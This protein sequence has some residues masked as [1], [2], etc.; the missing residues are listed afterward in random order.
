MTTAGQFSRHV[1]QWIES[2]VAP[3][4]QRSGEPKQVGKPALTLNLDLA[5][6]SWVSSVGLNEL[7]E[8]NLHAK[9]SGVR[10]VLTNV[11]SVVREVFMLTRLERMFEV[12]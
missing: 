5:E 12:I 9:K 3:E 4:P 2:Q 6:V 10:L 1:S 8:I 7:I 11:Q